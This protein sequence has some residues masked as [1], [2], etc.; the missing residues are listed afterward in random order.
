MCDAA[1]PSRKSDFV[2]SL[3]PGSPEGLT[4]WASHRGH[5]QPGPR[6][7]AQDHL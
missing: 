1:G 7:D 5:R 3:R 2:P 6:W 4:S